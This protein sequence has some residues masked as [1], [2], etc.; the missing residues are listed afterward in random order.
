MNGLVALQEK[1]SHA[2]RTVEE[3][4]DIVADQSKRLDLLEARVNALLELAAAQDQDGTVVIG[5]QP[6]PHW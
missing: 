5:D 3:L 1:L 2:E 6:P 4:S